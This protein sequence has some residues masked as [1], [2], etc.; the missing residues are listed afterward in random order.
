M[1]VYKPSNAVLWLYCGIGPYR[2]K[3][4]HAAVPEKTLL[5][6]SLSK[7]QQ[8][9]HS[10]NSLFF[11]TTCVSWH[12][13]LKGRT[14]L[15]LMREEIA[16]WLWSQPDHTQIIWTS[17]QADN[18]TSTSSV[19]T[20]FL[21]TRCSSWRPTN[22]VKALKAIECWFVVLLTPA[23]SLRCGHCLTNCYCLYTTFSRM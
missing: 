18:Y 9:Q 22:D 23:S 3:P 12:P 7:K 11:R 5:L 10:F 8:Q 4:V 20:Q 6:I 16:G 15:I 17:L 1:G 2:N 21:Q 13:K 14:I 19:I